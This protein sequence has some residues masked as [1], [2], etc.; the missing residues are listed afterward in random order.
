MHAR[1]ASEARAPALVT[2]HRGSDRGGAIGEVER[3]RGAVAGGLAAL[4]AE[5]L[6]KALGV[7][8][9]RLAR[10]VELA[11]LWAGLEPR[12]ERRRLAAPGLDGRRTFGAPDGR[13]RRREQ[14]EKVAPQVRRGGGHCLS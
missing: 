4:L 8:L 13:R 3:P 2:R 10:D 6:D 7:E 11:L 1:I 5:Q 9:G 12:P 14:S